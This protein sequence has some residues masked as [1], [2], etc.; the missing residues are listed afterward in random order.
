M[1]TCP[2]CKSDRAPETASSNAGGRKRSVGWL[3]RAGRSVQWLLP[4]TLLVLMPKCPMCVVGYVALCTGVG[5][6]FATAQ[7]IRILLVVC[8]WVLLAYLA[9]RFWR[10]RSMPAAW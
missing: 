3:R 5:I 1:S 4:A 2:F 8:C 9:V 10:A 6:S 7:W